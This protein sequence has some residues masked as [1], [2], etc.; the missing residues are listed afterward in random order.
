M[1]STNHIS[2]PQNNILSTTL[3]SSPVLDQGLCFTNLHELGTSLCRITSYY[4]HDSDYIIGR[5][6]YGM[7]MVILLLDGMTFAPTRK[8]SEVQNG[9]ENEYRVWEPVK[10]NHRSLLKRE[11]MGTGFTFNP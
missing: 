4:G 8:I 2:E 3:K 6:E 10:I 7:S 9:V 5:N 11:I 1:F